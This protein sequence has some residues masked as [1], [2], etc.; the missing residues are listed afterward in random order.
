MDNTKPAIVDARWTP[1]GNKLKVQCPRCG[2]ASWYSSK[3]KDWKCLRCK[4]PH[5]MFDIKS[6]PLARRRNQ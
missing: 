4:Y 5:S 1:H 6:Y 2:D 3:E